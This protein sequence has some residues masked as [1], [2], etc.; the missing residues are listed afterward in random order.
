[1]IRTSS[2]IRR[3]YVSP[4]LSLFGREGFA[5]QQLRHLSA[6]KAFTQTD[7]K[8]SLPR[9]SSRLK[10]VLLA[11]KS[12]YP[13]RS[14]T[15]PVRP[16]YT[17]TFVHSQR[18]EFFLA[19]F[20]PPFHNK[21]YNFIT[22]FQLLHRLIILAVNTILLNSYNNKQQHNNENNPNKISSVISSKNTENHS[23]Q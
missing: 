14:Y 10:D 20:S 18:M 1:M 4:K 15:V 21:F 3:I 2:F 8:F 19:Y 23:K 17:V 12:C 11:V 9:I 5:A 6:S 7:A 16:I 13:K 22:I